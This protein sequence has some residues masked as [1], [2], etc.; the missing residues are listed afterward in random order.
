MSVGNCTASSE[1]KPLEYLCD[2]LGA[3]VCCTTSLRHKTY[4]IVSD[5]IGITLSP[6]TGEPADPSVTPNTIEQRIRNHIRTID[7]NVAQIGTELERLKHYNP[8]SQGAL[9]QL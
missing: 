7:E 8:N 9:R 1:A 5:L 4:Q 3:T 2:M 6:Q